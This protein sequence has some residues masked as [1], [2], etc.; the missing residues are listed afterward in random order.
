MQRSSSARRFD[1]GGDPAAANKRD[2][3]ARF[4]HQRFS[5]VPDLSTVSTSFQ[6]D[7]NANAKVNDVNANAN[8]NANAVPSASDTE[9][10]SGSGR[11]DDER[12]GDSI[13]T[14]NKRQHKSK[15]KHR[16]KDNKGEKHGSFGIVRSICMAALTMWQVAQYTYK[17]VVE[18]MGEDGAWAGVD[19]TTGDDFILRW[20]FVLRTRTCCIILHLFHTRRAPSASPLCSCNFVSYLTP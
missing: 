9:G 3:R 1:D 5:S 13:D 20:A 19:D 18:S 12:G 6:A 16:R 11:G 2:K 10:D 7:A 17:S 8:A 15:L 14:I 4:E